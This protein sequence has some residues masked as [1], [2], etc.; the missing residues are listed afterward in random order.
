ME[1]TMM[2]I[3]AITLGLY[4]FAANLDEGAWPA[5]VPEFK[6]PAPRMVKGAYFKGQLIKSPKDNCADGVNEYMFRRSVFLK[7]KPA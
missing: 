3:A 7:A 2:S 4:A 6:T 1:K 5:V